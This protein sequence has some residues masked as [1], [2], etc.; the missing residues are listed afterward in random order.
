MYKYYCLQLG[1]IAPAYLYSRKV[2]EDNRDAFSE[3]RSTF[4][5]QMFNSLSAVGLLQNVYFRKFQN[6]KI[7]LTSHWRNTY[8]WFWQCGL[9][10]VVTSEA[11]SL[12]I[13]KLP[14]LTWVYDRNLE[15]VKNA[16]H[17][18]N[19]EWYSG[20]P[21]RLIVDC[22]TAYTLTAW[23][24]SIRTEMSSSFDTIYG[25]TVLNVLH[26]TGCTDDEIRML[27]LFLSNTSPKIKVN[28]R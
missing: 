10:L 28:N 7:I 18:E 21:K 23:F 20:I 2:L 19:V 17:E 15:W 13:L 8:T 5:R 6:I 26:D 12:H 11:S 1:R 9:G 4:F 14:H 22:G 24:E 3:S 27:H 25:E 16:Y